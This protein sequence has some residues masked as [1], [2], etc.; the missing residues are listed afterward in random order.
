MVQVCQPCRPPNPFQCRDVFDR[1][2]VRWLTRSGATVHW[3]LS[4][5]FADPGPFLFTL[6]WAPTA[7]PDENAWI[8]VGPSFYDRYYAIDPIQREFDKDKSTFYRVKLVT[9]RDT[10]YSD[11]VSVSGILHERDWLLA[12]NVVR[13]K[14]NEF[15][16]SAVNGYLLKRRASGVKC[17]TCTDYQT[18]DPTDANC[19]DCFGTGLLCGYYYPIACVWA[20]LGPEQSGIT[21]DVGAGTTQ[22][23]EV[24]GP[25]LLTWLPSNE[26][27]WVTTRSDRRYIIRNVKNLA[28]WRGVPLI[29]EA[30]LH[31]LTTKDQVYRI[32]IPEQDED[33]D[34]FS[35]EGAG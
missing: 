27:I 6:Q 12:R 18:G 26:D 11:A 25:M 3:L 22:K 17:P 4:E 2:T 1:V 28:D 20:A 24:V 35:T 29:G 7:S 10:Y 34:E 19:P 21:R 13:R 14:R 5:K 30:T 23:D 15:R 8:D 31:P 32:P 33:F 9:L 16:R